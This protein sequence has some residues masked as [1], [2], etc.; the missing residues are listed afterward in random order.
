ML[1]SSPAPQQSPIQCLQTLDQ[2]KL[3]PLHTTETEK[4]S[5]PDMFDQRM[6]T[7]FLQQTALLVTNHRDNEQTRQT[8]C[9]HDNPPRTTASSIPR[10]EDGPAT[11]QSHNTASMIARRNQSHRD[12]QTDLTRRDYSVIH[13]PLMP[14]EARNGNT[15]PSPSNSSNNARRQQL[16]L[17]RSSPLHA[18]HI[19]KPRRTPRLLRGIHS[20]A[21]HLDTSRT[22]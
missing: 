7:S 15:S 12:S 6:F 3:K 22:P 2:R 16:T 18:A 8:T 21:I 17:A 9:Q 4:T 19:Q 1:A 11:R 20:S 10:S 13:P 5:L 14:A